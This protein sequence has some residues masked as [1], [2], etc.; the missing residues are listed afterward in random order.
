MYALKRD[1]TLN[2]ANQKQASLLYL[3]YIIFITIAVAQW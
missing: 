2:V 3:M 1:E